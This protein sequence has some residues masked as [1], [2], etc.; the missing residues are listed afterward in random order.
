[1]LIHRY[2]ELLLILL[3]HFSSFVSL[4]SMD[5]VVGSLTSELFVCSYSATEERSLSVADRLDGLARAR[6]HGDTIKEW[7]QLS[8]DDLSEYRVSRP[9]AAGK[10]RVS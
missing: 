7:L 10:K 2:K 3:R 9:A 6:K 4:S 5:I 1:M 8:E